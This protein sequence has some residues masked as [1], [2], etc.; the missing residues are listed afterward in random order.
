MYFLDDHCI[1]PGIPRLTY[2]RNARRQ[3][4]K[5]CIRTAPYLGKHR[6]IKF[7]HDLASD[8]CQFFLPLNVIFQHIFKLID[9][10]FQIRIFDQF[11]SNSP[12]HVLF[13]ELYLCVYCTPFHCQNQDDILKS[14]ELQKHFYKKYKTKTGFYLTKTENNVMIYNHKIK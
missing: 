10:Q 13:F 5:C 12:P 9:H 14:Q 2:H 6:Y 3:Q 7:W 4:I 11:Q 8:L 1:C